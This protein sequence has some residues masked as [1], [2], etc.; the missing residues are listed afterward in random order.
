MRTTLA[1]KRKNPTVNRLR[2][3]IEYLILVM[4]AI[5]LLSLFEATNRLQVIGTLSVDGLRNFLLLGIALASVTAV[6]HQS[7]GRVPSIWPIWPLLMFVGW[8]VLSVLWTTDLNY[9]LREGAKLL[10]LVAVYVLCRVAVGSGGGAKLFSILRSCLAMYCIL[11]LIITGVGI[12]LALRQG[13]WLWGISRPLDFPFTLPNPVVSVFIL[14]E[15]AGPQ[16]I[17]SWRPRWWLV[18]AMIVYVLLSLT[19]SEIIALFLAIAVV[20]GGARRNWGLKLIALALGLGAVLTIFSVDNPVKDRM[21]W[22][23]EEVTVGSLVEIAF[24]SPERF[25]SEDFIKFSGRLR[26]WDFLLSEAY[27]MRSALFGAGIGSSRAI[28]A[29]SPWGETVGH[30]D[31]ATY[32]AELGYIG[33]GLLL[34][35]YSAGLGWSLSKVNSRNLSLLG[36]AAALTLAGQT[37]LAIVSGL[38]YNLISYSFTFMTIGV[39]LVAIIKAEGI[40]V[41][42]RGVDKNYAPQKINK[43]AGHFSR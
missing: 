27:E 36:Q 41:R 31:F 43:S 13:T 21:F 19:R 23:P 16:R 20:W 4:L 7:G 40:S 35:L 32:L 9:S 8:G 3:K 30:G 12:S 26:Y 34:L 38:V 37:V 1:L 33:F 18:G 10:Y 14:L 6:I 42:T 2:T 15:I 11:S 24:T 28:M 22:Q 25:L 17:P 29:R 39:I 5:G